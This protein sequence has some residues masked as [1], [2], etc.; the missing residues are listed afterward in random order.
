MSIQILRPG[1]G[2]SVTIVML[3]TLSGAAFLQGQETQ[4]RKGEVE[5]VADDVGS[6]LEAPDTLSIAFPIRNDGATAATA[7]RATAIA[8]E[9]GKMSSPK[10]MPIELGTIGAGGVVTVLASFT[11]K[12][13]RSG[14]TYMAK[15][16]G[17]YTEDGKE[18]K[19]SLEHKLRI[20][21]PRRGSSTSKAGSSKPNKVEGG[22]YPAQPPNFPGD[23][24][25]GHAWRVPTGKENPPAPP[26][27]ETGTEPAP[28]EDPPP[29]SFFENESTGLGGSTTNEP[30]GGV[31][32]GVV[33]LTFNWSAA[34]ST[35]N[36]ASF[37]QLDPTTIFPNGDDG[38]FCCD[39]IVQYAS[40]IN[41]ILWL[42]QYSTA[43]DKKGNVRNR[44]RLAAASPEDVKKSNGTAWTYW[45]FTTAQVGISNGWLDYPDMAV[46]TKSL[47]FSTDEVGVGRMVFRIPL[48]EIKAGSTVHFR[49]TDPNDGSTAYGDHLSQNTGNEIFWAGQN[50]S[51]SLRVF[52][53]KETSNT[54]FWN[55]VNVSSWSNGTLTST[56]PDGQDWLNKLQN[57]P[58]NAVLGATRRSTE[59]GKKVDHLW[60]AWTAAAGS[61][62]K[63]AQV[64][65]VSLDRANNF[66][67]LSQS[68][69]W[70]S[71]SAFA[72]PAF[73]SNSE[74][75]IGM[76]LENGGPKDFE[77]HGAGFWGDFVVY[78]TTSS[79]VGVTRFGDYVTIRQDAA[80]PKRFDAFGYGVQK[81]GGNKVP[82]THY[83]VFG[84]P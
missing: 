21:P 83:V 24:N 82:D 7:V 78:I 28:K 64:Q 48:S 35:N 14:G 59:K 70:S 75:E 23:T 42:L 84:R 68:Q 60:F 30:S 22:K 81:Q 4:D 55:S 19:F 11:G 44:Y 40:S 77:N 5:L 26:P 62:F 74:G 1:P 39:Q 15:V 80:H 36:G 10:E 38:G 31:G 8:V 61:G 58:G 29:I 37:T 67:K 27:A 71:A 9:G 65:W 43:T 76:S 66:H 32:G 41:R 53:W 79:N 33:F 6:S 46:G 12:G 52:S 13:F 50:S 69:V 72:Y 18:R 47:Y 54:Y 45:D 49:F 51:S 73:S 16:E 17:T 25:E 57:F 3:L 34:Y 20:P 56:T 2:L 63:Q